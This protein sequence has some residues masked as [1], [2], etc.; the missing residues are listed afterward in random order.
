MSQ[1]I[2]AAKQKLWAIVND[3]ALADPAPEIRV[4]LLTFGN[5]GHVPENGWVS[6]DLPLTGD[7][8]AVSE[9]LFALSTNGGTE[10]VGRVLDVAT[11]Q[12]DWHPSDDALKLIVVAG[13]ESAD[14]DTVVPFRDAA[15]AAIAQGIMVNAIYCGNPGDDIAP[16][17]R[18]VALLADGHFAAIDHDHG[19]VVVET[20]FDTELAEL[21]AVV[22]ETYIPIG[23]AG[24]TASANQQVQDA[25]AATLNSAAAASRAQTKGSG[26]YVCSWDLVDACRLNQIDLAEVKDEDLPEA[27]RTMTLQEKQA[28]VKSMEARR[29]SI[30]KQINEVNQQRQAF[31]QTEMSRAGLDES[32][33]FDAAIRKAVREQ[34]RTKGFRFQEAEKQESEGA[35]ESSKASAEGDG[36]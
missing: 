29:G 1:L 21:S 8:D 7:L 20:P 17:W 32:K 16:A 6:L 36:C 28:H 23:Q 2:E 18:E 13:N 27:M 30:Q 22:N 9:K 34:A 35:E 3:L 31:I 24:Q 14:Q 19:T 15:R 12:L 26:L 10:L 11:R 25:N 5:D 33:S 4:A